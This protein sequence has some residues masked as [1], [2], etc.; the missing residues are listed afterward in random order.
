MNIRDIAR[1]T[2]VSTATVSRVINNS[3]YVKQE[4][5][6]KIETFIRENNYVPNAVAR[7]L[8][9]QDT[10]SIGV[11]IPD[12]DNSF[13]SGVIR[14]V[15]GVAEKSAYNIL[16]FDTNEMPHIEHRFL[17]T[18]K[19]QRLKGVIATPISNLDRITKRVLTD[20]ERSGIPVILI[21]RDLKDSN[22]DGVF[23][24]NCQ[25]AY[26]ATCAFIREGHRRI[27]I[28]TG[29]ETS[30]PGKDRLEGFVSAIYDHR[31]DIPVHYV[32]RGD[33]KVESGYTLTKQLLALETPP[34]AIFSSNNLMTLGCLKCLVEQGRQPGKTISVIGF[35][36]IDVLNYINYR[37]SVVD[38]AVSEMGVAAMNLLLERLQTPRLDSDARRIVFPTKLILRGSEKLD[39][40]LL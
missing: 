2:G 33:F 32:A 40:V 28:I 35:D 17:L 29:P 21:D 11:I 38:R 26:D 27:S 37:L 12:I 19:E 24:D 15:C 10:S 31:L 6:E 30:K 4:T 23:I 16:F 22:F 13:F 9:K 39:P 5:R 36:D 3:G 20:L 7:S 14:G 1:A 34:T 25:G 8:S 18:V